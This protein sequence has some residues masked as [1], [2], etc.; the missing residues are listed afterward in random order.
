MSQ[1]GMAL[2]VVLLLLGLM[3]GLATDMTSR[4]QTSLRRIAQE[5]AL[6]QQRWDFS[7]AE[8]QALSILQQDLMDN[9]LQSNNSQFWAQ[10]QTLY[11]EKGGRL[12]WQLRSAQ[13]CFNLNSLAHS[14]LEPLEK[15]PYSAEVFRALLE[16][17]DVPTLTIN[18]LIA[19]IAD[20]IDKDNSPRRDGAEDDSYADKPLR[21]V[22]NQPFF[23]IS[24]LRTI[25]GMTP[26]L[27]KK[28]SPWLCVLASD[29]LLINVSTLTPD[30]APLLA[31]LLLN[32]QDPDTVRHLLTNPPTNGWV[33]PQQ[34]LAVAQSA[35]PTH[36]ES[37]NVMLNGLTENSDFFTLT[38]RRQYDG[39][40]IVQRS[41]IFYQRKERQLLVYARIP[42]AG[43]R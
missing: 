9:P 25:R 3:A 10:P 30:S 35:W 15:P 2:L 33:Y 23:D 31:A 19:A 37:L 17:Q 7:A 32:D 40:E 13:N 34:L 11:P 20:Y 27:Y 14:P 22:A 36:K 41:E 38:M 5:K 39:R 4:Y 42:D 18:M 29:Q 43:E 16:Q 21:Y 28:I 12:N 8:S 24:E 26:S 6:L 1:K